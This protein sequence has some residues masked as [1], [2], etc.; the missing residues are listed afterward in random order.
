MEI[1]QWLP[2]KCMR[3]KKKRKEEQ[4]ERS[5]NGRNFNCEEIIERSYA[6]SRSNFRN[7][8]KKPWKMSICFFYHLSEQQLTVFLKKS[9]NSEF[10]LENISLA[11]INTVK[12]VFPEKDGCHGLEDGTSKTFKSFHFVQRTGANSRVKNLKSRETCFKHWKWQ[13]FLSLDAID[14]S[15]FPTM[16]WEYTRV[17][18]T[19]VHA[20]LKIGKTTFSH[21]C[22]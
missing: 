15:T 9:Y 8:Y 6:V 22:I 11:V 20:S 16:A 2:W 21:E 14:N 7:V 17:Y 19:S 13:K 5:P 4:K 3:G 18:G 12:V 1:D 10:R